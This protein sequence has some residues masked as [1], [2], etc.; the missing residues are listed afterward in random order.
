MVF[1]E[2]GIWIAKNV[3]GLPENRIRYPAILDLL[4]IKDNNTG[5]LSIKPEYLATITKAK[6]RMV[7]EGRWQLQYFPVTNSAVYS[8]YDVSADPAMH[9]D[10]IREHPKVAQRLKQTLTSWIKDDSG[11]TE[12]H[13]LSVIDIN[14]SGM[15]VTCDFPLKVG[16][17][18]KFLEKEME[19][20][21]PTFGVV[22]WTFK[23]NKGFKAGI[24]FL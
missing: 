17:Q 6:A 23:E 14:D 16:H 1:A 10:V 13:E 19:W 18:I 4:E 11:S 24:K 22:M 2:T 3:R 7:R 5:T 21:L 8:L 20:N 12:T 15:G 9:Y